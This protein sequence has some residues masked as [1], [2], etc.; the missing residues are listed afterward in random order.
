M[1]SSSSAYGQRVTAETW[2]EEAK[3]QMGLA[4]CTYRPFV[5]AG[6]APTASRGCRE[7]TYTI[8]KIR[9][10]LCWMEMELSLW[11]RGMVWSPWVRILD[12]IFGLV[13]MEQIALYPC[14]PSRLGA[15]C[16]LGRCG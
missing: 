12:R 3:N 15:C 8:G 4:H 7:P 14:R 10:S 2:I 11:K 9:V 1:A 6:C 16:H 5:N 13:L